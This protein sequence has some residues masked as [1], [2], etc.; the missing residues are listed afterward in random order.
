MLCLL[1]A[2]AAPAAGVPEDFPATFASLAGLVEQ[3]ELG[4][5]E[6]ARGSYDATRFF[7]VGPD[8]LPFVEPRFLSAAT[9]GEASVAGLFMTVW[10]RQPQLDTIRREME[11]NPA[12]RR[13]LYAMV[14]TEEYFFDSMETGAM[15]QPMLRLLPSVGGTRALS[16]QCLRSRDPLVRRAGLFWGFWLADDAYWKAVRALSE[17]EKDATTKRLALRLLLKHGPRA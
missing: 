4:P 14:G 15:Y 8:G 11:S 2:S 7:A 13:W 5:M 1:A 9:L 6:M 17:T 12:K 3:E 10:G 16:M